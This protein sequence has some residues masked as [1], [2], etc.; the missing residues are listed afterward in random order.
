MTL[1]PDAQRF[2]DVIAETGA[3]PLTSM[4]PGAAIRNALDASPSA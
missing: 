2:L 4:T 3:P 1:H